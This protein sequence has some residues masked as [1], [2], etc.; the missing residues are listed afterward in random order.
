MTLTAMWDDDDSLLIRLVSLGSKAI[1]QY[2]TTPLATRIDEYTH[3]VH[4]RNGSIESPVQ[5]ALASTPGFPQNLRSL[6]RQGVLVF[7]EQRGDHRILASGSDING[8][9][10]ALV[11]SELAPA[12]IDLYGGN[13]E[14]SRYAGWTEIDECRIRQVSSLPEPLAKSIQLL[15]STSTPI[16]RL[17]GGVRVEDGH[18]WLPPFYVPTIRC[19]GAKKVLVRHDGKTRECESIDDDGHWALP[20]NL[21]LALPATLEIGAEFT[22]ELDGVEFHRKSSPT[23]ARFVKSGV[24]FNYKSVGSGDYWREGCAVR[25]VDHKGKTDVPLEIA[26]DDGT[27]S[28]DMLLRDASLFYLGPGLGEISMDPDCDYPW[29][30]IQLGKSPKNLIYRGDLRFP[31]LP[32]SGKSPV[33]RDHSAWSPPFTSRKTQVSNFID[34]RYVQ[35]SEEKRLQAVHAEYVA[36][37]R[38]K[39]R[40]PTNRECEPSN[41]GNRLSK[42]QAKPVIGSRTSDVVEAI[43]A[44]GRRRSGIRLKECQELFSTLT[45]STNTRMVEQVTRAWTE[46]G[47]I[48]LLRYQSQS[49][50]MVIART[51]RFVMMRRGPSVDATLLGLANDELLNKIE[52]LASLCTIHWISST[53]PY[54]PPTMRIVEEDAN[55]IESI[56][57][58][59]GLPNPMW[60]HWKDIDFPPPQFSSLDKDTELSGISFGAHPDSYQL[61]SIWDWSKRAFHKHTDTDGEDVVVRRLSHPQRCSLYDVVICGESLMHCHIRSWALLRAAEY[62]EKPPF[63]LSDDGVLYSEGESPMHLPLSFGRFCTVLGSGQPGPMISKDKNVEGYRY[64]FGKGIIKSIEGILPPKW[65]KK[66]PPGE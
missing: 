64:P 22:V 59:L 49:T 32:D 35:M 46:T 2:D 12:F 4:S 57:A 29:V 66:P 10:L 7:S 23:K 30:V 5:D 15:H 13:C 65:L 18:L 24:G 56:S 21:E 33:K 63:T 14:A 52:S 44:L 39:K 28:A 48:D 58:A 41:L 53:N 54:S 25:Q 55:S 16:P 19:I 27:Q 43:A 51:P 3:L 47:L 36:V 17:K 45:E 60:I 40:W 34:G 8:C 61:D 9:D 11:R 26:T 6:S 62:R 42:V 1:D 50:T 38:R 37:A 31:I 20:R